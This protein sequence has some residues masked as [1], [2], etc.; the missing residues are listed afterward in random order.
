MPSQASGHSPASP[1]GDFY[2][3]LHKLQEKLELLSDALITKQ[4]TEAEQ[5]LIR[6]VGSATDSAL[7]SLQKIADSA[8]FSIQNTGK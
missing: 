3:S 4:L 8:L 6:S 2:D 5:E 1:L 7:C